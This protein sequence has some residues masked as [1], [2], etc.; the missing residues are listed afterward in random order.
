VKTLLPLRRKTLIDPRVRHD[1]AQGDVMGKTAI[2]WTGWL[3]VLALLVPAGARGQAPRAGSATAAQKAEPHL[4]RGYDALR[5]NRYGDA[6]QEFRAALAL[7]PQLVLRARFPLAVALFESHQPGEARREFE[8]VRR[9]IGDHPNVMYYLGRLDLEEDHLDAAIRAMKVANTHPPFPDTAYYLGYAYLKQGKLALAEKWLDEA[10]RR[11]P[12]DPGVHYRLGV[13]YRKQGRVDDARKAFALSEQLR[14]QQ[15]ENDQLRM[16]CVQKLNQGTLAEARPVCQKLYDPH[17]AQ[18]LT[19]LGVLYAEHGDYPDA[20]EP[21]VLAARLNPQSPQMQYNLALCYFHMNQ[22]EKARGP[23]E[24]AVGRWPDLFELNALYSAVLAR[25]GD[26]LGAYRALRHAH[27]LNP[28]DAGTAE[29]LFELSLALARKS[30]DNRNY[31]AALEYLQAAARVRPADPEPHRRMAEVYSLSG[32]KDS[33]LR[34][35]REAA[36]LSSKQPAATQH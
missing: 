25:L 5:N 11:V 24:Q 13:L 7:D 1:G 3:L 16:E 30:R 36:R 34:E 17:D 28:Q 12:R 31:N 35:E 15:A 19:T 10:A 21:L 2:T 8:A 26:D 27:Q 22:F 9:V 18:R 23:L 32:Q 29:H 20:V 33:A 14:R 4:A 6:V